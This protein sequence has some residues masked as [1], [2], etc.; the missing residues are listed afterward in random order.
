[1]SGIYSGVQKRILD[2]EPNAVYIH[3]AAHSLNLVLNDACQ[4]IAEIKEYYAIVQRLY[5]FLARAS[6]DGKCW[7]NILILNQH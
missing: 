4:P 5:V 6:K 3:C 7:K 2:K 1:M